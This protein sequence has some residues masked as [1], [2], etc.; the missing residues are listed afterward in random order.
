[1]KD[2][3]HGKTYLCDWAVLAGYTSSERA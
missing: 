3:Q 2:Q 1:M